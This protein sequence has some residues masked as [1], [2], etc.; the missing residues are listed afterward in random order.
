MNIVTRQLDTAQQN[1][2]DFQ[3]DLMP[4]APQKFS[5]WHTRAA[6]LRHVEGSAGESLTQNLSAKLPSEVKNMPID[7]CRPLSWRDTSPDELAMLS[8]LQGNILKGH[9]RKH[10]AHVLLQFDKGDLAGARSFLR[11]MATHITNA[12]QQLRDA[13]RFR[14]SRH[15]LSGGRFVAFFLSAT[16]YRAL[17]FDN[18]ALPTDRSFRDG[19]RSRA[20]K[21]VDTQINMWD[22]PYRGEVHAMLMI[23]DDNPAVVHHAREGLRRQM[24]G[25]VRVVGME[26]GIALR[27]N[28][29]DETNCSQAS[30]LSE[31]ANPNDDNKIALDW[32]LVKCPNV[33]SDV[34]F[35][36]YLAFAKLDFDGEMDTLYSLRRRAGTMTHR[37]MLGIDRDSPQTHPSLLFMAYQANLAKQFETLRWA[38]NIGAAS[39]QGGEYFFAPCVSFLKNV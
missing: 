18:D 4:F 33:E 29:F 22:E 14:N 19:F 35:G 27:R 16:G 17:G 8:N 26:V 36:S 39:V 20:S 3:P 30:M 1:E 2:G 32:A 12:Y 15:K 24:N 34:S 11:A 37:S 25:G 6:G 7:L 9:G 5:Q 23:A 10:A 21:L 31:D 38:V 13:D 28:D